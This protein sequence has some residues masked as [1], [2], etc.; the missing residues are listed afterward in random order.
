MTDLRRIAYI[1][2]TRADF[3]LMESTLQRIAADTE[4]H[5]DVIVTGMHLLTE[6]GMTIRDIE[7]SGLHIAG[8]VPI[9]QGRATGTLM[10]QNIGRILEGL[11]GKLDHLRPDL[12]LLLGDRGEMLAGAIAALH[13]NI[14]VAHIHGGERSGTVDEPI[15]HAIS[16]LAHFHF[17]ATSASRER[18]VR[19][20]E[21]PASIH[22]TGAPG[23]DGLQN[24]ASH[25]R[26]ALFAS[27]GLDPAR[28]TALLLYHPVVQESTRVD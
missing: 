5:L 8:V 3:G 23:L 9:V 24:L 20:G 7:A 17:V 19:L 2:G 4:M 10:A 12:V 22:V 16:K 14:P 11:T 28:P 13:L 1:T 26:A 6:H 25:D 15:R 27:H 21:D 18:L